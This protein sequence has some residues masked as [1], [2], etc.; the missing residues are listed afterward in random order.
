MWNYK[1][2]VS[3][4]R[5][6]TRALQVSLDVLS[7]AER[8]ELRRQARRAGMSEEQWVEYLLKAR[9]YG[10]AERR[11]AGGAQG[12]ACEGRCGV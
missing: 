12:A 1:G 3:Q 7:C 2:M 11:L 6:L 8:E 10:D 4:Q 5:R 9:I